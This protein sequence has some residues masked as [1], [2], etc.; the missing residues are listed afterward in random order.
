[1]NS[2]AQVTSI[3]MYISLL[4]SFIFYFSIS[5]CGAFIK[6]LYDNFTGK[7]KRVQIT[8]IFISATTSSFILL[9][10]SELMYTKLSTN[11]VILVTFFMG[12]VGFELFAKLNNLS[13]LNKF[14]QK[15]FQIKKILDSGINIDDIK[16]E[17]TED[18]E[19]N[20]IGDK[21]NKTDKDE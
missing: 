10:V 18:K 17:N 20:I 5:A 3:S 15:V 21:N 6:D 12:V 1:M 4:T 14:I 16:I 7:Q 11:N 13:G 9:G 8:E 19:K 2:T